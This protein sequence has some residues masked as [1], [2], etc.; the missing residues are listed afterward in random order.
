M[1]EVQCHLG[2]S[3]LKLSKRRPKFKEFVS[4]LSARSC[5]CPAEQIWSSGFGIQVR[6]RRVVRCRL[7][8]GRSGW[9][10]L[11]APAKQDNQ[12]VEKR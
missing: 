7:T 4:A 9:P 1:P 6:V 10:E 3:P 12:I 2:Y 5:G 11:T 8:G